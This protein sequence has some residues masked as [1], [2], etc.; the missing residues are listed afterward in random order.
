MRFKCSNC[1]YEIKTNQFILT[2]CVCPSCLKVL[3]V[4]KISIIFFILILSIPVTMIL[5]V[6]ESTIFKTAWAIIWVWFTITAIKPKIFRFDVVD[7][8][9]ITL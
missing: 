1:D 7:V 8:E 2:K 3:E 5:S 9:N 4:S 6:H